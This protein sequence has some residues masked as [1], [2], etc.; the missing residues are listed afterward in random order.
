VRNRETFFVVE[1]KTRKGRGEG[2]FSKL[3]FSFLITKTTVQSGKFFLYVAS[4][5]VVYVLSTLAKSG[6]S[7]FKNV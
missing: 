5:D 2:T 3:S 1:D 4:N 6:L 7:N